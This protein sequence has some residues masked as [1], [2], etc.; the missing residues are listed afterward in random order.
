MKKLLLLLMMNFSVISL[1]AQEKKDE[2][3]IRNFAKIAVE[4]MQMYKIPASITLSQGLLET[5]NGQSRLADQANNHFGIKCKAEWKGDTIFHDDDA[6]GECFRKYASARDSYTDH[7]L[8]LTTRKNYASLFT[9]DPKDYKAW[10][11][12]LKKSGYATNSKYAYILI[13]T[14]EKYNLNQFD[15][16]TP[17]QVNTKLD[18]LY[19][20]TKGTYGPTPTTAI[21]KATENKSSKNKNSENIYDK[22]SIASTPNTHK[23]SKKVAET[24]S[25]KKVDFPLMRVNH[26]PN[27]NLKYIVVTEND[28]LESIASAYNISVEKLIQYNDLKDAK[29]ITV[30]QYI[31]L[32]PKNS[33]GKDNFYTVENGDNMYLI[34]QKNAI[35]LSDLYDK[36]I[37]TQGQEPQ[38][39]DKIYLRSKKGRSLF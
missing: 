34:A 23:T 6:K 21:A 14:I 28:T 13:N 3:Y 7:S 9:L 32:E 36:N 19:P 8:F 29:S 27:K 2:L 33:K 15:N 38:V 4:E 24:T 39:G 17:E 25:A 16:L 30:N 5:G 20:A 31:F 12:G 10:A 37:M 22:N 18:E 26:H 1:W 35:N 11:H